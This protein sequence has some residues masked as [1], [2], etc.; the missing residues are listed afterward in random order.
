MKYETFDELLVQ[1][2][3][4]IA[5]AHMKM[6]ADEMRAFTKAV[7]EYAIPLN[8]PIKTRKRVAKFV[9]RWFVYSENGF[10]GSALSER[11]AKRLAFEYAEHCMNQD[12]PYI[13][14]ITIKC[15]ELYAD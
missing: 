10:I 2:K 14:A 4:D 5:W 6:N 1:A 9:K 11:K 13:P 3:Y 7:M 8:F 15:E 12:E